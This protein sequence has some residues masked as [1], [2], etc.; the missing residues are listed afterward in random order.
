MRARHKTPQTFGLWMVDVIC[1]SLGCVILLWLNNSRQVEAKS[2]SLQLVETERDSIQQLASNR[3]EELSSL[4]AMIAVLNKDKATA[5]DA[6]KSLARNVDE[7]K[8]RIEELID[9][10]SKLSQN[11]DALAKKIDALALLNASL[12]KDIKDSGM[13]N[14]SKEKRIE[15]LL[16][17][18]NKL[19]N[20]KTSIEKLLTQRVKD[21][22]ELEKKLALIGKSKTTLEEDLASTKTISETKQKR[23]DELAKQADELTKKLL[24]ASRTIEQLERTAMLLP[25]MEEELKGT[26]SKLTDEEARSKLMKS[27]LAKRIEE[28][29]RMGKEVETLLLA[30]QSLEAKLKGF[31]KEL[32]EAIAYK[33]RVAEAEKK[34]QE[35]ESKVGEKGKD[36]ARMLELL[37]KLE[38]DKKRILADADRLKALME[39]RFAGVE[40]KGKNVVF[41]V[42][43]SGSMELLDENTPSLNKWASVREALAQL[44]KSM[45]QLEKFQIIAFAEELSWPMGKEGEWL[46]FDPMTTPTKVRDSLSLIKPSG[47]TNLHKPFDAAFKLRKSGLDTVYILSDGLPSDGEGMTPEQE[48][49]IKDPN[50]RSTLLSRDLRKRL[51][52]DWNKPI[53]GQGLVRINSIGFFYESPDVGAFLWAMSREHNGSF[54]GMSN[55]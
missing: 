43:T 23:V 11:K 31:S 28:I 7:G 22:E 26:R 33:E 6:S 10:L 47:G 45:S 37:D 35:L 34:R 29:A 8:K 38:N 41:I 14:Q 21:V 52:E 53:D 13:Q 46:D 1:C 44:M 17:Q 54:V 19:S 9:Q 50:L 5:Q 4:R 55:P 49:T 20:T 30:K 15:D 27:D 48:K 25:K 40:L 36:L 18:L 32:L 12:E 39:Q 16:A 24:A 42:D 51:K 3:L 2:K